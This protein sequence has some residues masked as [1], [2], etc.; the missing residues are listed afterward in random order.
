MNDNDLNNILSEEQYKNITAID[1]ITLPKKYRTQNN[2]YLNLVELEHKAI[3][4][5]LF[6]KEKGA[7]LWW[8]KNPTWCA[9][10]Q[11]QQPFRK[12]EKDTP[13]YL[14]LKNEYENISWMSKN[15]DIYPAKWI[16]DIGTDITNDEELEITNGNSFW[17]DVD[18][19]NIYQKLAKDFNIE[20]NEV[21]KKFG[22]VRLVEYKNTTLEYKFNPCLGVYEV[23]GDE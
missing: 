20:L 18:V 22:E 14:C 5:K 15:E 8:Q 6:S 4:D 16:D 11:R 19:E 3:A 13:Y 21:G 9:E 7:K 2:K 10:M 1:R 23:I 17:F 12:S